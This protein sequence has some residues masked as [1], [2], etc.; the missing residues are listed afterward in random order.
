MGRALT[1]FRLHGTSFAVRRAS[2]LALIS[3]VSAVAMVASF[4]EA[5]LAQEDPHDPTHL[6]ATAPVPDPAEPVLSAE[7][8][9][10]RA[11]V[12]AR[13]G[14]GDAGI[15]L[16]LGEVEDEINAMSP[17]VRAR[18]RDENRLREYVENMVRLELLGREAET[19]GYGDD[20]EVRRT[21]LE[22]AVQHMIRTEIDERITA[23]SISEA[24][25]LVYYEAHPEE[26]SR[27]EM[28]RASHIL[29]ATREEALALLER[30]RGGD[31]R[32]FRALAQELS[33][34]TETRSRGGDLRY[35][36]A[37]GRGP[38][39]ADRF[40]LP[41]PLAASAC[42]FRFR[43]PLPLAA[44]ACRFRLPLAASARSL[45]ASASQRPATFAAGL[46]RLLPPHQVE[47]RPRHSIEAVDQD[48]L[49]IDVVE[50]RRDLETR[51]HFIG[52]PHRGLKA[53]PL[54]ARPL[55]VPLRGVERDAGQRPTRLPCEIRVVLPNRA[56][57]PAHLARQ[58]KYIRV[59]YQSH[60]DSPA[61][62]LRTTRGPRPPA[63]AR[64]GDQGSRSDRAEGSCRFFRE[65][66]PAL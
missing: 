66:R 55:V 14:E 13:I 10:R 48:R 28:R 54:V 7:E 63:V 20:P 45:A 1:S 12:V 23:A 30:A 8:T 37:Q 34:D 35:F 41:L 9:A 31:M 43:L 39:T 42:R 21:T 38:N 50:R 32:G 60:L 46:V 24:E 19:R 5:A 62:V 11:Q 26:F 25:V 15:T 51:P 52:A 40:R 61:F 17:F 59:D 44:S 22:S 27:P 2:L 29:V 56:Q 16:T 53:K 33:Q 47:E 3:A 58:L 49:V 18:Y 57:H 6:G 65:R 36:D 64:S 4:R